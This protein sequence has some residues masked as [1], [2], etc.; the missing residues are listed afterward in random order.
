[1]EWLSDL[2]YALRLFRKTPLF[3][4][5]A[6]GT[7]ALGIGANSVI[8]S[9]V[10]AVVIRPLPYADP[11]R[12]VMIWEDASRIGFPKNTPAPANF[13]DWQRMNR[14]FDDIAATRGASA[15]LTGDGQPE[16]VLGRAVTP[17]F[18]RVLGVG[19]QRGRTFTEDENRT[20]AHVVVISYG[21][22]QRRYG[23]DPSVVGRTV[24]MNDTR[25]EV[26]GVMPR[27]FVFRNRDV[28]YWVPIRLSPAQA[29]DRGSHFLN[30]V[31]RLNAGVTLESARDDMR[32][33]ARRLTEQYPGTN[34][35]LG[36]TLVPM[37][38]EMLGNTGLELLVLMG[39]ALAVLLIA[40]ANLASLL[41][42][43]AAGR[44]GELAVR[45][46]L[47]AT[48]G[49]LIRQLLLEGVLLSM[50]G[51]IAGLG[52]V[53][54]ARQL[55]VS[56]T[57]MGVSSLNTSVVDFRL[58]SF[59]FTLAIATG[60]IFSA[61][62]ALHVGAR[63][64]HAALHEQARSSVGAGSQFTRDALVILQI[65]AAVV[66][67]AATG[68]MIRTLVNLRAIDVGFRTE[69]LLT[70]RTTLPRPKY[71]DPLKRLV[72]YE[73]VIAGVKALPGVQHAAFASN[74]P[75]TAQGNTTWF[76]IDGVPMT[77]DL[78]FDAMFRAGTT[79]YL[80]TLGVNL[81]AGRLIDD[82]DGAGTNRVVVINET[83]ARQYFPGESSL[84]R[85]V[86]FSQS[87]NPFHTVVGVVR[88][89][90]ERGYELA[91]KPG[92]Y[93]SIAQAP[94]I[95]AVPEFLVVRVSGRPETL[96]ESIRHVIAGVDPAQP[97]SAV[98]TMDDIMDLEVADRH[99]QMVL[100]GAFAALAIVVASIG[101]YGLLAF[102]VA[103]RSREIGLRIA[104]GAT[105]RAVVTM[106][107]ARGLALSGIGLVIGVAGGWAATRAMSAVLYGVRPD[108]APTYLVVVLVLGFISAVACIVP[109]ARA[110]RV[111]PMEVLRQE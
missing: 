30:V 34:R 52:L 80:S 66:L 56:L 71:A 21:L 10:D 35:N 15:S 26:I 98:R 102:G 84:G 61:A 18:F 68:L 73:R 53:P 8:F 13:A 5:T 107:A 50:T 111:D 42:S 95:W 29:A 36:V 47:G 28:D 78:P 79:D 99:Q 19:P 41:M 37:K 7:L 101:L 44:R 39:A 106:M 60:V 31:S 90:R 97:I 22:W 70:M 65:A 104:L 12:V 58:L 49:R 93:L 64:L 109:A 20:G 100:L 83:M 33:I 81:I 25:Y 16:Q 46:A 14:S 43:R 57:P 38:E 91:L 82:R 6:V 40:C 89:V 69:R 27:S 11:D 92:V 96:A 45:A 2:R 59:T 77:A 23:G 74:P 32:A 94:E 3:T 88:D 86:Q 85:R 4:L 62:P 55:L 105:S 110:S 87:S 103:Q 76:K 51:G 108:D 48:R 54:A 72:F 67:L 9:V 1:M 63:S 17:N 24:L 75:F